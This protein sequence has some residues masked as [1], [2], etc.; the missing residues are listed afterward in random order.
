[1]AAVDDGDAADTS[2]PA[3]ASAAD[4]H[5]Y[6]PTKSIAVVSVAVARLRAAPCECCNQRYETLLEWRAQP[7]HLYVGRNVGR[8]AGTFES[9]FCNPYRIGRGVTRA[10]ALR[11]YRDHVRNRL[12]ADRAFALQALA[13]ITPGRVLGC[14]CAPE[15]CHATVLIEELQRFMDELEKQQ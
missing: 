10:D 15:P 4:N 9:L 8:V 5:Y 7:N 1:M 3:A 12:R 14:W 2:A 6:D 13:Q 11:L